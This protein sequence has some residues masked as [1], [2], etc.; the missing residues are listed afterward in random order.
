MPW[1]SPV[2][3]ENR[4]I[5]KSICDK[6]G[7]SLFPVDKRVLYWAE[8]KDDKIYGLSNNHFRNDDSIA[9][10]DLGA[11]F[12]GFKDNPYTGILYQCPRHYALVRLDNGEVFQCVTRDYK[13]ITNKDALDV[14]DVIAKLVFKLNGWEEF[15]GCYLGGTH[16]GSQT[17]Y[18]L[19]HDHFSISYKKD[20]W[21]P[22]L[23][24]A[25]S[26]NSTVALRYDLGFLIVDERENAI[27]IV[28]E[29]MNMELKDSHA[30]SIEKIKEKLVKRIEEKGL[31]DLESLCIQ[32]K[33]KMDDL[34]DLSKC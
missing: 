25:N 29:S 27:A 30:T 2:L 3:N 9:R 16:S 11:K 5:M 12:V 6:I 13:L 19:W 32:F 31:D 10:S 14:A 15:N 17:V 21:V 22:F 24:I 4:A 7:P 26:Y 1:W 34:G 20:R 23:R 8:G 33:D 18:N 28:F